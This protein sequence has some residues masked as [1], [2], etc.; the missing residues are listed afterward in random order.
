MRMY[1]RNHKTDGSNVNNYIYLYANK[2]GTTSY[3][4]SNA[5]AFRSAISAPSTT[6]SGASGTWGISVTGNAATATCVI[7][8]DASVSYIAG[9]KGSSAAVY[10]KKTYNANHWYP[11]VALETKGGGAWQIGN[12]D[13]ETLEFRYATKANRDSDNNETSEIYMQNGDTGRV[14][15]NG[16]YSTWVV[17]K[18]GGTFSGNVFI[19]TDSGDHYFEVKS[20]ATGVRL[21]LDN[22]GS[23][24]HG[25]W[26]SGYWNGSAYT[27]SS[28]WMIYRNASGTT[29]VNGNC[30]GSAGSVAWANTGHPSTFPPSSHTHNINDIKWPASHNLV[31]SGANTEWS[32]DMASDAT[33]SYWHV[34]SG[35]NSATVLSCYNSTRYVYVPVHLAVGG[36]DNTS[37]GLSASSIC[38]N[39]TLHGNAAI[40]AG[41]YVY[42]ASYLQ[43]E[44]CVYVG[45]GQPIN[46]KYNNTWYNVLVNYNNGN[47]GV[48]A[49]GGGVYLG[50]SNSTLIDFMN[51]KGSIDSSGNMRVNGSFQIGTNT[52]A[53]HWTAGSG[54]SYAWW[55]LRNS[56]NA[57]IQNIVGYSDRFQISRLHVASSQDVT[58]SSSTG[59]LII[60]SYTGANIGIDD[61]EIMARSGSGAT[62]L[63]V[64]SEGGLVYI[65]SGGLQVNGQIKASTAVLCGDIELYPGATN[66]GHG[67]FIDFHFNNSSADFTSRIIEWSSGTLTV[68]TNLTATKVYNAVWNDFAE[69]RESDVQESGRVLVSNG[70]GK[71]VLSTERLQPAAHIISDTFGCSVGQ[72]DTAQTPM[73]VAGRVLAYPYQDRNNYK[74]GDAVC[75]AP[76][77]TI[78]IMTREEIIQYPDR[79][80]GIVDEIPNY[81]RWSQVSTQY[82]GNGKYGGCHKAEVEVKGRIWVYVK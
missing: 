56:S 23:T 39:G 37:Y 29:I 4:V 64:N 7:H 11:A 61:N 58:T 38:S 21:E 50:Y 69:F 36:Y 73:G 13:D 6:G 8:P 24:N 17:P 46:M 53:Y 54:S 68:Y 14:M 27:A 79:I 45:A 76:N 71:L 44:T 62:T 63:Y 51:G 65:G 30:T 42:A 25:L 59:G 74:V 5:S 52:T 3:A 34:W 10:A 60:G 9:A 77:G 67:G 47:T 1:L 72:S 33:G 78:D 26:S 57:M 22:S 18:T 55:D 82:D 80:I 32:I 49:A 75:A 66:A 40:T 41:T 35:V 16:N 2:D 70:S 43:A 15:T 31:C 28:S 48:N 20:N 81:E 12:Y 19:V